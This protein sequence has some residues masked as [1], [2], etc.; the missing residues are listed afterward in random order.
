[1]LRSSVRSSGGT[2]V[3]ANS[4]AARDRSCALASKG[5]MRAS[6]G[7][8]GSNWWGAVYMEIFCQLI[9]FFKPLI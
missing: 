9:V 4:V 1:M 8:R 7:M 3:P 2:R 5:S 6:D